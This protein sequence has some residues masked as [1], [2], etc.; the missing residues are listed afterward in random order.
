VS[1]QIPILLYTTHPLVRFNY[2]ASTILGEAINFTNSI[3]TFFSFDGFKINYSANCFGNEN[4]HIVPHGLLEQA[5]VEPQLIYCFEWEGLTAFFET[6][7]NIPFDFFAASFYLLTRYEEY[8]PHEKDLFGRYN[9]INSLAFKKN[10]LHQPLIQLWMKKI[11]VKCNS[12]FLT[13]ESWL[14]IPTYDIDIAYS[15]S[16]QG[17]LRNVFGFFRDFIK[18]NSDDIGERLAVLGGTKKDPYDVYNWLDLLHSSLLLKPIYFFLVAE[19]KRGYDKNIDPN[20]AAMKSLITYHSKKYEIGIHPSIQSSISKSIL[21]SEINILKNLI[22]KEVKASRNHYIKIEFPNTYQELINSK[23]KH[24]YSMGYP[25]INGFRASY[26]KPYQWFDLTK[27]NLTEL[28]VHSFC[29]M[30]ATAIFQERIA[31]DKAN[32]DL[33]YYLDTVKKVGGEFITIFHNNF[34]TNQITFKLW[35]DLYADFLLRNGTR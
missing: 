4:L 17:I 14:F 2:I 5:G 32:S 28:I 34:L 21:K 33:Q 19:N 26:A 1:E 27:N 16:Y 29:Y 10:F 12:L 35:K 7:G 22:G 24:D 25:T 8:L 11:S 18:G 31:I 3:E 6:N 13:D 9:H 15:Y 23:I 20:S 30:D